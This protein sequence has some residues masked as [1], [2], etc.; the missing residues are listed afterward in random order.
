MPN[1]MT[2]E[3]DVLA[4]AKRSIGGEY[5]PNDAEP[6]MC[7]AQQDYFRRLLNEWKKSIL[8]AAA[9]TLQQLQDGPIR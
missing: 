9:G 1:T 5:L 2:D 4:K 6:Y 3:I 7:E 8:D